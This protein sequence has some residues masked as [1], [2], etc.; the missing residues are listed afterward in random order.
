MP[1]ENDTQTSPAGRRGRCPSCGEIVVATP[2]V[3]TPCPGCGAKLAFR[4]EAKS[5]PAGGPPPV[6]PAPPRP[7]RPERRREPDEDDRPA[8]DED[9]RP[10]RPRREEGRRRDG[11][12][13]R[14][15][16][17]AE[18]RRTRLIL[19]AAGAGALVLGG[20]LVAALWMAGVF[21]RTPPPGSATTAEHRGGGP[22][23]EAP[24]PFPPT[25]WEVPPGAGPPVAALPAVVPGGYDHWLPLPGTRPEYLASRTDSRTNKALV[26]RGG[27]DPAGK[28]TEFGVLEK[29]TP[30]YSGLWGEF[31]QMPLADVA[32][33]GR[34]ALFTRT[35]ELV[36]GAGPEVRGVIRVWP[37]G[38]AGDPGPML[39]NCRLYGWLGWTAKGRLLVLSDN[40]LAAYDPADGKE[41]FAFPG[42]HPGVAAVPPSRAWVVVSA[43][44][45]YLEVL[46]AETGKVLGRLAGDGQWSWLAVSPDGTRLAGLK[47]DGRPRQI[48]EGL[49]P[50][51]LQVWDLT[52]GKVQATVSLQRS[53]SDRLAWVGR[54][55]VVQLKG[56]APLAEAHLVDV[57][58]GAPRGRL[59]FDYDKN[60]DNGPQPLAGG[61]DGRLWWAYRGYQFTVPLE[62]PPDESAVFRPG[63][64]VAVTAATGDARRDEQVVAALTAKLQREGFTVADGGWKYHVTAEVADGGGVLKFGL[65]KEVKIPGVSGHIR[66]MTPDGTQAIDIRHGG[67]FPG[68]SSRYYVKT[69]RPNTGG[70]FEGQVIATDYYDF[71]GKDPRAA[72]AEEAWESFLNRLPEAPLPRSVRKEGDK[73]LIADVSLK[74][75]LPP[76]LAGR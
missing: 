42:T 62:S 73:Y 22:A 74:L 5:A 12:K 67:A 29:A 53:R 25:P 43:E 57:A 56:D 19:A 66:L 50:V 61:P 45:K 18:A 41:V 64:P 7:K 36:T 16:R 68:L 48:E 55:H 11:A 33:D 63:V 46:D 9:D 75:T 27:L 14:K 17:E 2:G 59:L 10:R 26:V 15:R 70:L 32:P 58:A 28:L 76:V 37:A 6:P 3:P 1:A 4:G 72:M 44:G 30:R 31:G 23:E 34:L 60:R 21:D 51:T 8:G 20:L 71:R 40:K 65:G 38:A 35:E 13:R 49:G 24:P 69:T 54:D 39:I 52:T 47:A